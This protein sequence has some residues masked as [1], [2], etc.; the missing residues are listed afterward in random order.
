[1]YRVV[2][3]SRAL[4]NPYPRY[5]GVLGIGLLIIR[6]RVFNFYL[7]SPSL[8]PRRFFKILVVIFFSFFARQRAESN[9]PATKRGERERKRLKRGSVKN[10]S[11]LPFY[12]TRLL[13]RSL[14]NIISSRDV[15]RL[16]PYS[17]LSIS[18][19]AEEGRKERKIREEEAAAVARQR[20]TDSRI[21]QEGCLSMFLPSFFCFERNH[22]GDKDKS[23]KK[24]KEEQ[25]RGE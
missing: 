5:I 7:P 12:F 1:M 3:S 4:G 18:P 11:F 6:V 13:I 20:E 14:W 10:P 15:T 8:I 25:G 24:G 22:E 21:G 16:Q 23:S 2:A 9:K 17:S 19:R